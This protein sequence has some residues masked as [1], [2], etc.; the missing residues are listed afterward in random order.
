MKVICISGKDTSAE[1]LCDYL[2]NSGNRVLVAHFG[3]LLKYI[4]STFFKWNG[5]KDDYGRTL[6]QQVGTQIIRKQ[7]PDFWVSFISN[8]LIFFIDEWDYVILPD[9]RFPNEY[10]VFSENGIDAVLLRINR[11]GFK[12]SLSEEQ[13]NHES[14]TALD[15]YDHDYT[16]INN[17]DIKVLR[18]RLIRFIDRELT[19]RR[20]DE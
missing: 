5:E 4:C 9:C 13:Q 2:E 1:I 3:D 20:N 16:I 8:I 17:G 11:V 10:E 15:D 18:Q 7:D 12:S 19:V 6:L 14:E